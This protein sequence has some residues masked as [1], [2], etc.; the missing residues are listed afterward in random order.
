M[1]DVWG[2]SWGTSWLTSWTPSATAET[3]GLKRRKNAAERLARQRIREAVEAIEKIAEAPTP[4]KAVVAEA[5]YEI[6][7]TEIVK[8]PDLSWSMHT[9]AAA[10]RAMEMIRAAKALEALQIQRNNEEWLLLT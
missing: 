6:V 5:Q 4:Q 10:E 3:P 2:G 9:L 1:A 8:L 7:K